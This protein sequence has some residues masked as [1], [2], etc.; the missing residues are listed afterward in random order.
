MSGFWEKNPID[1]LIATP[2]SGSEVVYY[3]WMDQY[4]NHWLSIPEGLR[5]ARAKFPE[6]CID[7]VRDK[8]VQ[9]ALQNG[10]NWLF[11]LDSDVI[12]PPNTLTRLISHNLPIVAGLYVRRHN[13]PFNEMLKLRQDGMFGLR[14]IMDGEYADGSLVECDAVGTGCVL[15]RTD[16][17][18]KVKPFQQTIDGKPARP[19][20]FMWTESR[21]QPGFSEDFAFFIKCREAGIPVYCDTAIKARH[22]GPVKFVPSGNNGISLEFIGG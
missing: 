1:V 9:V 12:V 2:I 3:E 16:V 21:I 15:I 11:F 7:I 5:V 22:V 13:P 8:A 20:Y 18:S 10:T 17:F 6:P 14:P 19:Q 4:V